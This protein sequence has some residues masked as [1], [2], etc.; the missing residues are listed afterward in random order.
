NLDKEAAKLIEVL[1][2]VVNSTK[3]NGE[4]LLGGKFDSASV[5]GTAKTIQIGT[6]GGTNDRLAIDFAKSDVAALNITHATGAVV[7]AS[8]T[9]GAGTIS[10]ATT[11]N[12]QD[13]LT[14]L[15]AALSTLADNRAALG[16]SSN[17]LGYI[18]AN[19]GTSIEQT[20]NTISAIKDSDMALEMAEF[21]KMKIMVQA[22][23]AMVSQA[24]QN[25]QNIMSLFK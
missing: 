1:D 2:K 17:Q 24:N 4:V 23:T 20:A 12:A 18:A 19:L 10:L 11:A 16:A 6:G 8:S 5:G 14:K 13:A 21:T 9:A 25:S 15:D 3:F 7:T 22:G